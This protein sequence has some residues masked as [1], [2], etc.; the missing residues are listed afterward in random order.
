MTRRILH[1]SDQ[2]WPAKAGDRIVVEYVY[3]PDAQP[4]QEPAPGNETGTSSIVRSITAKGAFSPLDGSAEPQ[5]RARMEL[6]ID[7]VQP[8]PVT[9]HLTASFVWR[10]GNSILHAIP[11]GGEPWT[12]W[13]YDPAT[14]QMSVQ[15]QETGVLHPV[16]YGSVYGKELLGVEVKHFQQPT[17]ADDLGRTD[18]SR[19]LWYFGQQIAAD[20]G[21]TT[22]VP[23][24]PLGSLPPLY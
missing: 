14:G 3:R 17:T 8:P 4:V 7:W 6:S 20:R 22:H 15:Y 9:N 24:G 12:W 2:P 23:Q 1:L 10:E 13:F 21:D 5:W 18:R 16:S 11:G 19:N